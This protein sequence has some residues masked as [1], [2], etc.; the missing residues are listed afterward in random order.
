MFGKIYTYALLSA[1][2]LCALIRKEDSIQ[3]SPWCSRKVPAH[4]TVLL[5]RP[6]PCK[7]TRKYDYRRLY[8]T[9]LLLLLAGDIEL[10]PGPTDVD[11]VIPAKQGVK[12]YGVARCAL[13]DMPSESLNL[14]SRA[15]ENSVI[16]CAVKGCHKFAHHHC[17]ASEKNGPHSTSALVKWA[18]AGHT[19]TCGNH[20][21]EHSYPHPYHRSPSNPAAPAAGIPAAADIPVDGGAEAAP[22]VDVPA[23]AQAAVDVPA[24]AP[25]ASDVPADAPTAAVVPADV[26]AAVDVPV[27][28]PGDADVPAAADVQVDLPAVAA[29]PAATNIPDPADVTTSAEMP[30]TASIQAA[31]DIS[32]TADG[33]TAAADIP[34]TYL[35]SEPESIPGPSFMTASLMDVMEAL[36]ITQLKMDK[37]SN[38]ILEMRQEIRKIAHG[39]DQRAAPPMGHLDPISQDKQG[40]PEVQKQ[41]ADKTAVP[42]RDKRPDQILIVGDSNVRR[43]E[44]IKRRSNITFRSVSGATIE[45]LERQLPGSKELLAPKVVLHIGANDLAQKG[46][47]QIASGLVSLAKKTKIR[48]GIRQVYVCSVTSRKD[49][50]SFIYSRSE[51]VNNRLHSLC[52][53]TAGVTFIDLR[54]CLDRCPFTGLM[55]DGIHYNNAGALRALDTIVD[56]T[57]DFLE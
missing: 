25:A 57:G 43:L 17:T 18:C 55:R 19:G 29:V 9:L 37:V 40:G 11:A 23:D 38:D 30:S 14:R 51:S 45:Q 12:P 10:N 44:T 39:L 16:T 50:G 28:A 31:A 13:C 6:A 46:S 41:G 20:R 22:A 35:H 56:S 32:V 52:M 7:R 24:D 26:H 34:Y 48:S 5:P 8:V 2:I 54:Q 53:R 27:D 3:L 4:F 47:E 33:P 15:I 36:R 21:P 49:L 1:V 42:R